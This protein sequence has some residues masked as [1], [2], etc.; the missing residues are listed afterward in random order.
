MLVGNLIY[1][2]ISKQQNIYYDAR[3]E[4]AS[5]IISNLNQKI[6]N[7]TSFYQDTDR[8]LLVYDNQST[9]QYINALR[10]TETFKLY[11]KN[12]YLSIS[13]SDLSH[14]WTWLTKQWKSNIR[15][16]FFFVYKIIYEKNS[17]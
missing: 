11:I 7:I 16:Y 17:F 1:A 5:K 14:I 3:E 2:F 8:E 6:I 13:P 10:N 9:S 4:D 15:T 12:K